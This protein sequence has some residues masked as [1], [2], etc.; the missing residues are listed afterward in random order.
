MKY[1]PY[2]ISTPTHHKFLSLRPKYRHLHLE[3]IKHCLQ[4]FFC[5][6]NNHQPFMNNSNFHN[7]YFIRFSNKLAIDKA[8]LSHVGHREYV[9]LPTNKISVI[10]L[11]ISI[12]SLG[13]K[14]RRVSF[15]ISLNTGISEQI[16]GKP[17]CIAS[18]IGSPK[19]S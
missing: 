13:S 16:I 19:P 2:S 8:V 17:N 10:F 6:S 12:G 3:N 14:Y 18:I 9:F 1:V 4:Y 7:Q 11:Q 5:P 15:P